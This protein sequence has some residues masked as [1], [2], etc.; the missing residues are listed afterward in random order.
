MA[1]TPPCDLM[2]DSVAIMDWQREITGPEKSSQDVFCNLT[3]LT[4][5]AQTCASTELIGYGGVGVSAFKSV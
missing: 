2:R 1:Q 5:Q 4:H 3:V